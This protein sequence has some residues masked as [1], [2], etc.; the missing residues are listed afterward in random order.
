MSFTLIKLDELDRV[1]ATEGP[2]WWRPVRRALGLTAFGINAYTADAAGN[3]LIERHDEL[4]PGA[5]GHEELYL[6]VSGA[7]RFTVAGE[8]VEARGRC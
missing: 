7:A 5:G 4:S 1:R 8:E 3:E 2:A 6:V